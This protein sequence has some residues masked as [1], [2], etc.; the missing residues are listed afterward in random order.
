MPKRIYSG[1]KARDAALFALW[2]AK[3][4]AVFERMG[5]TRAA[6]KAAQANSQGRY[7][8]PGD[9]DY[10]QLRMLSNPIFTPT[11]V[12]IA[13]CE[14]EADIAVA[15]GLKTTNN[16]PFTV[17]SG[18][19][20]TAGFSAG[21]GLLIDIAALNKIEIDAKAMTVT[22]GAG[23]KFGALNQELDHRNLHVPG[24][25][26]DDV[27]IGGYVQGGGIGFTSTTYGM[28][29]DNVIEMR[30]MLADGSIVIANEQLNYDLWWAMRGGTGGNFGVLLSVKY[31]LYAMEY[32]T[33][34]AVAWP[35][36]T[37]EDIKRATDVMMLLQKQYMPGTGAPEG[38]TLQVLVV[39]QSQLDPGK[40][41]E[42]Q[43]FPVFM[44]R[45]MWV[46]DYNQGVKAMQPMM[47]MPGAVT[48]FLFEDRYPVV[49]D[50]LL[51]KPQEQ[52]IESQGKPNQDKASRYVERD[53]TR[54]EWSEI[55]TYFVDK[56]PNTLTYMYLEFYGG[57]IARYPMEK[58]AFI[59]R[60]AK[61]DAVM[62]VY[63][64]LPRERQA[65]E[66]FLN[67]WIKMMEKVWNGEVYQNYCKINVPDYARNYWR[68]ALPGLVKV[69]NKYDR[70]R[71]F[72]FAQQ[73]PYEA[74]PVPPGAQHVIPEALAAALAR[75]IDFTGGVSRARACSPPPDLS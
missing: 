44:V 27:A 15:L 65:N 28:N 57:A 63:W 25:E 59:H 35:L 52:P 31:R 24:G 21:F 14:T 42:N 73:V 49:L 47:D 69:K 39:Y 50:A 48:Q 8:A 19:H 1:K 72:T 75:E 10:D 40:Q 11:P 29:C 53:L 5:I 30:V 45:G 26:C 58:S 17:R 20:C 38:L 32:V 67:G 46:G 37:A 54:S 62:D 7:V 23:T 51:N 18:G 6:L 61:F 16:L 3:E 56:A 13:L 43:M 36:V 2:D 74:P 71:H 12:L 41:P 64:Y 9:P 60:R 34:V 70:D 66:D 4:D 68:D 22:V 55:L 33:G